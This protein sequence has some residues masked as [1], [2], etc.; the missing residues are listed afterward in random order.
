MQSQ[1][2]QH[3]LRNGFYDPLSIGATCIQHRE[4]MKGVSSSLVV[5]QE[6][7]VITAQVPPL[8]FYNIN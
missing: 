2:K 5:T 4:N 1:Y 8:Y 3:N 7:V 6:H